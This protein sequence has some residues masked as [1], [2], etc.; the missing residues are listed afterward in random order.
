MQMCVT[1]VTLRDYAHDINGLFVT[2]MFASAQVC[3]T[4]T[5]I[6]P[7]ENVRMVDKW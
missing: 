2:H 1:R 5:A 4:S 6:T 3:V 7:S